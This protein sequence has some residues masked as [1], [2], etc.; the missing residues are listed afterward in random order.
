VLDWI[1][2][3]DYATWVR[4]S[5]GW[6]LAL[7]FH[8]FGTAIIVGLIFIITLR[9]LGFFRSI[10]YTSLNRLLPVIWIGF[11]VQVLSGATLWASKPAR[12]LADGMFQ[13][14]FAFVVF[15]AVVTLF[16]H[17]LLRRETPNWQS[18]GAVSVRGTRFVLLTAL[19]WA[20]V[21]V[22]GRLT[23][24]LGQLYHA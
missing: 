7:T 19:L 4:Q 5:W 9:L 10:P 16:F 8:A 17:Q 14:K 11:V 18:A 13:W 6:A 2:N 24:Y 22:A 20:A 3:T 23:A 1:A 12:Y 15:A 21:L